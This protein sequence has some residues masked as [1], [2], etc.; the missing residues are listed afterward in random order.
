MKKTTLLKSMLLLC[1]LIAGSANVWATDVNFTLGKTDRDV[2]ST[3]PVTKDGITVTIGDQD[4]TSYNT[5]AS[6]IRIYSGK[7]FSVEASSGK[8]ITKLVITFTTA[9][10]ASANSASSFNVGGTYSTSETVGTFTLTSGAASVVFTK[11]GSGQVRVSQIVVTYEAPTKVTTPTF[12]P[13]AGAVVSGTEVAIS[14]D[15]DGATI[16]YTT[17]GKAPSTSS[18]VYDPASKPTIT[19]A[20]TIKAYAVKAGLTDSDVASASYT[21]AAPC[22]T[23][24]FTVAEGEVD[25]GTSVEIECATAGATI[26]YTTD[27]T[28]PTTSSTEYSGAIT[29]NSAVTIKA[30]AAKD[31]NAN[32]AVASA[33]Y[34]IRDY[35]ILPFNWEGGTSSALAAEQGV[36]TSGLGSDYAAGNAP[37]RVRFDTTGDY[38]QIKTN[39]QPGVVAIGVKLFGATTGSTITVKGSTDGTSFDEGEVLKVTVSQNETQTLTSTRTF[40]SDVRY[41]RLYYTQKSN[42]GVGPIKITGCEAIS[43]AATKTFATYVTTNALDFSAVSDDIKAYVAASTASAGSITFTGKDEVPAG[44]PLLIKTTSA[45][46][47]VNVP[48]AASEPAAVGTNYLVAGDGSA[49]TYDDSDPNPANNHYY[50]ILTNGQFKAA[51][52]SVV[53]VGKAYLSLPSAV[54]ANELT[55]NFDDEEAGDVTGIATV[56]SKKQNNGEYYNLNGQRVDAS[57]KGIVI[58][59]GKKFFNK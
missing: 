43:T 40:G 30:I 32:S 34:T 49:I 25:K 11:Q 6:D 53:A 47:T 16:Y 4:N 15:I 20:T 14:C 56:S 29:I 26:Y 58:V 39:G 2:S 17:D 1:A 54:S 50:Y 12:D 24:T 42:V 33:T 22:D 59:N 46:V 28:T 3:T 48:V 23:P 7:S 35:A 36:T 44:T 51:N 57:H 45:G 13:E 21:V 55:I 31:G 52:N 37:Y 19:A 5:D 18:T 9:A 8:K 10:Y 27:G 38:I 41:V